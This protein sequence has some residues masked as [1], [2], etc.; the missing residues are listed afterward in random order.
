[1][2]H[3]YPPHFRREMIDRMLGGEAVLA[4]VLET[5]VPEQTLHRWKHQALIDAGLVEGVDSTQ[6]ADLSAAKKRIKALEEE[7]QLGHVP[8]SGVVSLFCAG[9]WLQLRRQSVRG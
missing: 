3:Q 1:M 8:P 9:Q 6:N 5:R 7:L 4:L 2:P